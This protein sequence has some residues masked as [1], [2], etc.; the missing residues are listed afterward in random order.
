MRDAGLLK[1]EKDENEPKRPMSAFFLFQAE[2]RERIKKENPDIKQTE[3][4]KKT[5]AEWR[6]LDEKKKAVFEKKAETDKARYAKEKEAY[7]KTKG[8]DVGD[9]RPA[10]KGGAPAGKKAKKGESDD[11]DED[12]KE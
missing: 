8:D 10:K 12:T 7:L 2:A 9:K 1:A 6:E 4:L 3:I 5:G 11:D